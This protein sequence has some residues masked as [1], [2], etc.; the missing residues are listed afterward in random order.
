MSMLTP[1]N[2]VSEPERSR[3]AAERYAIDQALRDRHTQLRHAQPA[4]EPLR[5]LRHNTARILMATAHR[6][7]SQPT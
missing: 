6:I 4:R 1:W 3:A 7:D 5:Q 2:E